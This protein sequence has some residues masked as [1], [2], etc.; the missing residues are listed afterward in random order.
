MATILQSASRDELIEP[1]PRAPALT[2]THVSSE[3]VT[4]LERLAESL[5]L[6]VAESEVALDEQAEEHAVELAERRHTEARL[7]WLELAPSWLQVS[8]G[9]ALFALVGLT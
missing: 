4:R 8:I 1:P 9:V 2:P 7:L 5:L 3:D 6:R